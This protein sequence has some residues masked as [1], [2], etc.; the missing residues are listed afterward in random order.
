MTSDTTEK[1]LLKTSLNASGYITIIEAPL[2][3][4]FEEGSKQLGYFIDFWII[5]YLQKSVTF[6]PPAADHIIFI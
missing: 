2:R 5:T 4:H 1:H 6:S 3:T